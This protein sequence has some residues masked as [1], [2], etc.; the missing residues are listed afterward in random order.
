VSTEGKW[1]GVSSATDLP[2][3]NIWLVRRCCLLWEKHWCSGTSVPPRTFDVS[4][5]EKLEMAK[6]E[7]QEAEVAEHRMKTNVGGC[8]RWCWNAAAAEV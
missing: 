5:G 4:C 7:P 8:C 2:V 6:V 3:G 1:L